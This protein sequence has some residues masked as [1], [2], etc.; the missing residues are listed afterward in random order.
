MTTRLDLPALA[1]AI[2]VAA[3]CASSRPSPPASD[4]PRVAIPP[5]FAPL[6]WSVRADDVPVLFPNREARR[7]EAGR[8]VTWTVVDVRRID[9]VPGTLVVEF[10]GGSDVWRA[11]LAFAD[12]RR[13]CDPDLSDR[14]HRCAE[15]GAALTAVFDAL[16]AEL[17]RGR[18]APQAT[19]TPHGARAAS[20]RDPELRLSLDMAPDARGAWS[21]EAAFSR[22][23]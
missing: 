23:P 13:D 21:V 11:R 14:A 15:P 4:L 16:Q 19:R 8:Q 10:P 7:A 2:A 3:G 17:A 6:R 1:A 9:G 18:G 12:P 22:I 5:T 20:W